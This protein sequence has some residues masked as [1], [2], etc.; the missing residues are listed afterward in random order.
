MLVNCTV[1]FEGSQDSHLS[2]FETLKYASTPRLQKVEFWGFTDLR[3]L[4]FTVQ[5]AGE[6]DKLSQDVTLILDNFL[7]VVN[8]K[9][10]VDMQPFNVWD[11][12]GANISRHVSLL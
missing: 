9:S 12:L 2:K 10:V 4:G 11:G 5:K 8:S 3:T 1:L 6:D 7:Y